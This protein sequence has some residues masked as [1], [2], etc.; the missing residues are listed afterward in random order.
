VVANNRTEWTDEDRAAVYVAWISND[1]NIRATARQCGIGH[2]TVAY[3]VKEWEKNGP[4][5]NLNDRIRANAYEFVH[6]AS[7]VREKAM[8][9]LEELIPEAEVKQLSAIATVVGIMDDKIRLA[10]GLATK[11]TETVHTLPT[12]EEMK[13][14]MSGFADSLVTAA[15]DRS[16]EIVVIEPIK[17]EVNK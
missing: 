10:Q 16:N 7:S 4:P 6:H 3:W 9:K 5:E 2:T 13:E 14:L 8:K 12:K 15:E 1:K 17:V 11:R